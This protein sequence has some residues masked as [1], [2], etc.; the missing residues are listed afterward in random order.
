MFLTE[1]G[2]QWGPLMA[3]SSLACLPVLIIYIAL[4]RQVIDSFVKAG[5]R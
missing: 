1:E 4:Q 5:M 2:N 3:I